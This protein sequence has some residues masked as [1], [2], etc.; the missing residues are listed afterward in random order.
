MKAVVLTTGVVI[1]EEVA[2]AID[3]VLPSDTSTKLSFY[4]AVT[5]PLKSF[6][7]DGYGREQ[8]E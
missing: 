7:A 8:S 1:L 5:L 4:L 6:F 2:H 3:G